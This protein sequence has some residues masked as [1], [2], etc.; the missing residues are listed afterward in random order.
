MVNAVLLEKSAFERRASIHRVFLAKRQRLVKICFG[1]AMER[2]DWHCMGRMRRR[3][4][5]SDLL[6]ERSAANV[7]VLYSDYANLASGRNYLLDGQTSFD[8]QRIQQLAIHDQQMKKD[9][10]ILGAVLEFLSPLVGNPG[11]T[12]GRGFNPAGGAPGGGYHGFSTGRGVDP[13]GNAT[14]GG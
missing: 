3:M 6:S 12:A 2:S 5:G 14:G 9:R 13:V 11:F 10:L 8:Q 4:M 7:V 1:R